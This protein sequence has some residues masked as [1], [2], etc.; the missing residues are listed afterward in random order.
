VR[1]RDQPLFEL[2]KP[3]SA[4]V[5]C[6]HF[7]PSGRTLVQGLTTATPTRRRGES[8]EGVNI[9][10]DHLRGFNLAV[11]GSGL[12][13]DSGFLFFLHGDECDR[14]APKCQEERP[15]RVFLARW[16]KKG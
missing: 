14:I 7:V 13:S 15:Q 2:K 9:V 5:G 10:H 8:C 16:G 11:I 6:E 3:F 1:L 4:R 12:F